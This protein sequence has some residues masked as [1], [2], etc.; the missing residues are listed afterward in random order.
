M[1]DDKDD[2]R[3]N[4]FDDFFERFFG[5]GRRS[6]FESFFKDFN[7]L[8][9]QLSEHMERFGGKFSEGSGGKPYVYGFNLHIGPDGKP[10]IR[11]FGNIRPGARKTGKE[12]EYE[13]STS[14]YPEDSKVKVIADLPG[15]KKEEIDVNASEKEVEIEAEGR[16]RH[17]H[18]VVDLSKKI[19]PDSGEARYE[20]GVLE[21]TFASKE[22]EEKKKN[23]EVE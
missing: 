12:E 14:T 11:K 2:E 9:K 10:K 22:E 16:G 4:P 13:P 8:F 3:K 21:L 5:S 19:L 20:N 23:I 17:Y 15:A 1:N 6:P 18:K 7:E